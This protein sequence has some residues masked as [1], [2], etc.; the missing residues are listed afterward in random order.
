MIEDRRAR[1]GW[2]VNWEAEG[3]RPEGLNTVDS[4]AAAAELLADAA[5]R[6]ESLPVAVA[7]TGG[8]L[9]RTLGLAPGAATAATAGTKQAAVKVT[10]DAARVHIDGRPH[11]FVAHLVARRRLW[12]GRVLVVA[13]A[14]FMGAWNVAPRAHPGD[15]RL[16]VLD[17]NPSLRVRLAAR[18]R[19]ESG[20]HLPHPA[21][22]QRRI[23]EAEF[24]LGRGLDVYLDGHKI[25]RA[26]HL[27]V[28]T[29]SPALEVW[30]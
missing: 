22:S 7:L 19:L 28:Q 27:K 26:R 3:S 29:V 5:S 23:T 2:G 9:A 11:W 18:R 15:G 4:D 14:S 17:A 13:N 1:V 25:A 12:R 6:D 10:A 20:T 8:D 24:D 21:V 30:I 16:D